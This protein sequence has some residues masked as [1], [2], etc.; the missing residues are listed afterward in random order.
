MYLIG[1]CPGGVFL[2]DGVSIWNYKTKGIRDGKEGSCV[3]FLLGHGVKR[4][5]GLF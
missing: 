3:S 1:V 4:G 2:N 5:K